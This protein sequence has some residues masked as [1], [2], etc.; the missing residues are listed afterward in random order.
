MDWKAYLKDMT[1][2]I[3]SFRKVQPETGNAY[4]GLHDA[5]MG[6][7]ALSAGHK[8]LMAVAIG[9][10]EHCVECIGYHTKAA[11]RAGVSREEF[12]EMVSVAVVMGGGPALMYGSK[13][14]EA[15]DQLS[16]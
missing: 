10:A 8:E 12:A 2:K 5:A 11:I 13:A 15:F 9:I 3:I 1:P 6:D 16:A 7:G 14:M 4:T